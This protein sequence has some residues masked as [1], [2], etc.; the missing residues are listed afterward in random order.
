M[1][2]PADP[3]EVDIR[4]LA[5]LPAG[6]GEIK[7]TEPSFWG[8]DWAARFAANFSQPIDQTADPARERIEQ[9]VNRA[10]ENLPETER[11]IIID[12]YILCFARRK[13]AR[14]QNLSEEKIDAA[15][16]RAERRLRF[17]LSELVEKCFRVNQSE[18]AECPICCSARREKIDR[19]LADRRPRES[20]GSLR[21]R[22]NESCGLEI[23]R[24]QTIMTHYRYHRVVRSSMP[25]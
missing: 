12:Y 18:N 19:E 21:R 23:K 16:K 15:R 14:R 25:R 1:K 3:A 13:I 24:V 11:R 9:A 5:V 2:R 4:R 6:P 20:W 8:G 22:I 10:I 7:D 17:M